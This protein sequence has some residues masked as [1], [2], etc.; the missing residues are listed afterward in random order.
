MMSEEI[1]IKETPSGH[2]VVACEGRQMSSF[3]DP[4][5]EAEE[6]VDHYSQLLLNR[7]VAVVLGIGSGYHIEAL[8]RRFSGTIIVI[9]KINVLIEHFKKAFPELGDR[10]IL[11]RL[12]EARERIM[13]D[14]LRTPYGVMTF[15]PAVYL[16]KSEYQTIFDALVGRTPQDINHQFKLRGV[17]HYFCP[18]TLNLESPAESFRHFAREQSLP[19]RWRNIFR[20]IGEI[21]K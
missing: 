19:S 4:H 9:E 3:I 6:W 1:E 17:E 8:S 5:K 15:A 2:P 21:V 7:K 16:F 18:D 20:M 12:S 13:K 10:V 11:V 14:G